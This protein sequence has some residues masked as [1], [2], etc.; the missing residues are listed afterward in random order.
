MSPCLIDSVSHSPSPFSLN[1]ITKRFL[2]FP[3]IALSQFRTTSPAASSVNF[4]LHYL[5]YQ[6]YPSAP[7]AG[8]DKYEWYKNNKYQGSEEK[9]QMYTTVMHA[10]GEQ[11]GIDF[12]FTGTM[13]NTFEAHRM[14]YWV[15]ENRGAE[16][17]NNIVNCTLLLPLPPT[18]RAIKRRDG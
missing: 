7:S 4:H 1:L 18:D 8:E 14:I 3:P 17:V 5:P 16:A 12:K 2:S 15:Q 9:M 11:E 10:E 6:L 13:A